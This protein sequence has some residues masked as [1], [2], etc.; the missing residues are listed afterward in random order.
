MRASLF[1]VAVGVVVSMISGRAAQQAGQAGNCVP[2]ATP[3]PARVFTYEHVDPGGKSTTTE[4]WESVTQT[5]SRV[6]TT[7]PAG[8]QIQINSF[9]IANDVAVLTLSR[10]TSAGGGLIS[11][12]EFSPGVVS[13]PVFRACAGQSWT[14]PSVT[15]SFSSSSGQSG[16]AATPSGSL[17][18]LAIHE[19][20]SVPAG[21]FDTVHFVRGT[22]LSSDEYWKSIEHG[23]IVK[24]VATSRGG[25]VTET[26]MSIK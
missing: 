14:I 18:I 2:I 17:R 12:T 23:V 26:L 19:K 9:H 10:K 24:H 21:A 3:Q 22:S 15:A 6:K 16:S 4:Q 20:I 1:V 11:S 8:V 5:G 13:D 7:G 25:G